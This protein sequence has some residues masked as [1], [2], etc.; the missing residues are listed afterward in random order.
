M[1][2]YVAV[3]YGRS[4][5]QSLAKIL[6]ADHESVR[7]PWHPTIKSVRNVDFFMKY[8]RGQVGF[9][10]LSHLQHMRA[11]NPKLPVITLRRDRAAVVASHLSIC[12]GDDRL[13]TL[14]LR[15]GGSH[16]YPTL[17]D[18]HTPEQG[19]GCWWDIC[20]SMMDQVAPPKYDLWMHDLNCDDSLANLCDW[21]ANQG[22]AFHEDFLIPNKR[23]WDKNAKYRVGGL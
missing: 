11:L 4:G 23:R 12:D 10:N 9:T 21:L 19:W 1:I 22:V 18:V 5:T 13:S 14:R 20:T 16:A 3:S 15:D 7:F 6:G 17:P 2:P 8:P